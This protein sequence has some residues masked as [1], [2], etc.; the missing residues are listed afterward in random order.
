MPKI[1]PIHH[2]NV[3]V[4]NISDKANA[5]NSFFAKKCS[6][7][8]SNSVLPTPYSITHHRLDLVDLDPTKILT[9]IRSLNVNKANGWDDVS[10]CM[11]K[12]CEDSLVKPLMNI[13]QHSLNSATFPSK[14]K[15]GNVVPIINI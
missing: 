13:F 9:L 8:E 11:F 1:P 2:N 12:I 6:P 4:T 5:F 7:L 14:W 10:V 3:I 15:R